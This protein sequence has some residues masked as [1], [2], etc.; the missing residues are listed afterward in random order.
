MP[1][2]KRSRVIPLTK[3]KK[4]RTKA[5]KTD[6]VE[7]IHKHLAKYN[8]VFVFQHENMTSVPFRKIQLEWRDSKFFL[9]KNKLMK[10]A[11][12]RT[13]EEA[14][15]ENSH[16]LTE[17]LK[18]DCGLLMT[19][20]SKEEILK[21]FDEYS[22]EEYAK[23]GTIANRTLI[24]RKGFEDLKQFSHSMEPYLR[25]LGLNTSLLN[26][27]IHLNEDVLIAEKGEILTAEQAKI[28]KLLQ[29]QLAEFKINVKAWWTKKGGFK[30]F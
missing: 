17:Y 13:E 8:N 4:K 1:I 14:Y 11:L 6:L 10:I 3:T 19:N 20:K 18:G 7:K 24:L 9:G 26:T 21:F 12:G 2:T 22:T 28:L 15:G 16:M 23:A 25:K 29:I 27:E 5:I 30:A